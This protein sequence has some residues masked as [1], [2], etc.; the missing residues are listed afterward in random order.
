MIFNQGTRKI[1]KLWE[2]RYQ[3]REPYTRCSTR[4]CCYGCHW[5]GT[6]CQPLLPPGPPTALC[7]DPPG[8]GNFIRPIRCCHD[9]LF[10]CHSAYPGSDRIAGGSYWGEVSFDLWI[11]ASRRRSSCR[12]HGSFFRN[13]FSRVFVGGVANSVFHPADF[14]I[15]S[16]SV[17]EERH[18]RAFATHT[19]TGSIGYALAPL[20][21]AG[22]AYEFGWQTALIIAGSLGLICAVIVTFAWPLLSDDASASRNKPAREKLHGGLCYR[23]QCSC[24][25]SSTS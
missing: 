6:F 9:H 22:L 20:T 2:N 18:G 10:F 16:A 1:K 7:A 17:A 11:S 21:M 13:A 4:S 5:G 12:W 3:H 14:S 25:S 15:L 19:F 23:V 8:I 24:F